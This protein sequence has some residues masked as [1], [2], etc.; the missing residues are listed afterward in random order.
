MSD[1][2]KDPSGGDP[3]NPGGNPDP[4]EPPKGDTVA[5]ETY[6]RVLREKKKERADNEALRKELQERK[7]ADQARKEQDLKDQNKWKEYAKEQE[8]KAKEIADKLAIHDRERDDAKKV[9]ACLDLLDGSVDREYLHM[10]D[11]HKIKK[12]PETGELDQDSLKTVVEDFRTKHHRLID[13]P[14]G[15]KGGRKLPNGAPGEHRGTLT[16][17]EWEKLPLDEQKKRMSEVY[18]AHSS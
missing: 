2:P 10:F 15:D 4:K 1:D 3:A 12:H 9:H 8:K 18:S 5:Y 13:T 7:D 6:Q 14:G 17:E 16:I 11:I